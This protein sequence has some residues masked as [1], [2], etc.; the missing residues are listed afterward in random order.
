MKYNYNY[1]NIN[2]LIKILPITLKIIFLFSLLFSIFCSQPPDIKNDTIVYNDNIKSKSIQPTTKRQIKA[3]LDFGESAENLISETSN[4][5][6]AKKVIPIEEQIDICEKGN[7]PLCGLSNKSNFSIPTTFN[8]QCSLEKNEASLIHE[9]PCLCEGKEEKYIKL[10]NNGGDFIY[11]LSSKR[12]YHF[13]PSILQ[14]DF[15]TFYVNVQIKSQSYPIENSQEN[16]KDQQKIG[17]YSEQSKNKDEKS[18]YVLSGLFGNY[19]NG[20]CATID[21]PYCNTFQEMQPCDDPYHRLTTEGDCIWNCGQ[22]TI[23]DIQKE[24]C[25]CKKGYYDIG[26]DDV[27][28]RICEKVPS[29]QKLPGSF[30]INGPDQIKI[31]ECNKF[32]L[33]AIDENGNPMSLNEDITLDLSTNNSSNIYKSN[34]CSG[35]LIQEISISEGEKS[36]D[37]FIKTFNITNIDLKILPQY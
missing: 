12:G 14:S 6:T 27:G 11:C 13:Q 30:I 4:Q 9:G 24:V 28:R 32:S 7:F 31:N 37:F 29:I 3:N 18:L 16:S 17:T 34:T 26:N 22:N 35:E 10:N 23:P 2:I 21:A 15:L 5:L 19:K 33:V 1:N 36:A 8:N 25:V 20:S